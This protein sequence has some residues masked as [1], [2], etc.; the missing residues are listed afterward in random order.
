MG[1]PL[2]S[3]SNF[4][5]FPDTAKILY[6]SFLY[7]LFPPACLLCK[8]TLSKHGICDACS[9]GFEV[10]RPPYCTACGSKFATDTGGN[11]LC[12]RCIKKNPPFDI[13]VSVYLYNG[14]LS[15]AVRLLKYSKKSLVG[16]HL[17]ELMKN[18][19]LS[20]ISYDAIVAVPL[21]ISR[22][23]ERGFNQS[24]LLAEG[25][26][27]GMPL[28]VDKYILE[29]V[30][31]TGSQAG[32]SSKERQANVRGAF[33]LRRGAD[34]AGKRIL[35]IDDVYTTGATVKECSTVLKKAGASVVNVLTLARVVEKNG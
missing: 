8:D 16:S 23:R 11:H 22:L 33:S 14:D 26:A 35:L 1:S 5:N 32:M 21:H 15:R 6:Q 19:R 18:H 27:K 13:A 28:A 31:P 24:Q 29:R 30:R 10:L 17:G 7:L 2:L 20:A 25:L 34:V 4:F 3:L 9:G 12:G